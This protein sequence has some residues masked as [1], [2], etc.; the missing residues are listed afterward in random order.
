MGLF[1]R[2]DSVVSRVIAGETL[3]VPIR[4]GVGDL[5]A[6]YSLN[7]VAALIWELLQEP[8]GYEH[9]IKAVQSEFS[10]EGEDIR[11]DIKRFLDEMCSL[12]L[13]SPFSIGA[14]A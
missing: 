5:A 6:I 1:V 7:G 8:R 11:E 10:S 9:I 13:I 14:A 12:G 2:S 3:I 4:R